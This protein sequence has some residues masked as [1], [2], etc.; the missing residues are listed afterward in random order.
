MRRICKRLLYSNSLS[1]ILDEDFSDH[2]IKNALIEYQAA[3]LFSHAFTITTIG[4][5]L[6]FVYKYRG[7]ER[8][9][10]NFANIKIVIDE[11]QSYEPEIV[12]KAC[13]SLKQIQDMGGKFLII[14]ATMPPIFI[15]AMRECGLEFDAPEPFLM[16]INRRYISY[17]EEEIDFNYIKEMAAQGKKVLVICNTL[18]LCVAKASRF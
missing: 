8:L 7:G 3:R 14:T 10:A 1:I 2:N 18:K 11:L 17:K 13:L 15:E 16:D 6:P 12:A 4:Q 9:L 5:V